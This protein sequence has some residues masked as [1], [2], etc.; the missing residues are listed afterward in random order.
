MAVA[1]GSG[2]HTVRRGD[3]LWKIANRYGTSVK[4]LCNLNGISS[5]STL[6]PGMKLRVR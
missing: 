5:R 2:T 1:S 6:Y 4:R 3:S